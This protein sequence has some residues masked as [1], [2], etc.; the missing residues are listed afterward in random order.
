MNHPQ[1]YNKLTTPT[2]P[3]KTLTPEEGLKA[4]QEAFEEQ[5]R[6]KWVGSL[7]TQRL[8]QTINAL[9]QK[10]IESSFAHGQSSGN[11][12]ENN[13]MAVRQLTKAIT[14]NEIANYV[15]TG[16]I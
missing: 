2:P 16:K 12:S 5:E 7:Y 11:L 10:Y 13:E 4:Q 9:R 14:L 15:N 1:I 8:I 3:P 6:M